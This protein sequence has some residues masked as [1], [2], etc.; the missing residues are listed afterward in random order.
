MPPPVPL[1]KGDSLQKELSTLD[2]LEGTRTPSPRSLST[3]STVTNGG[4]E[5]GS[6]DAME[7]E[8][9]IQ[10]NVV[11]SDGQSGS[12]T[13]N[14]SPPPPTSENS[15][16]G[17]KIHPEVEV[18]DLDTSSNEDEDDIF[19]FGVENRPSSSK[20]SRRD[21]ETM[22]VRRKSKNIK[23]KKPMKAK[24]GKKISWKL[25]PNRPP[26]PSDDGESTD[27]FMMDEPEPD[28]GEDVEHGSCSWQQSD[29]KKKEKKKILKSMTK[30]LTVKRRI[31][32]YILKSG[33]PR[34]FRNT[35]RCWR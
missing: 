14:S 22:K 23:L 29:G 8:V 21:G 26:T 18:M 2:I 1:K 30:S 13:Q 34:Q 17:T 25:P 24:G 11:F 35:K 28:K 12:G 32:K 10:E 27:D 15:T 33:L 3:P 31:R 7:V 6:V 16:D 19:G 20:S 9:T 4:S 5:G